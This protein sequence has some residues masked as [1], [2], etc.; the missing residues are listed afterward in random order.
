MVNVFQATVQRAEN[1]DIYILSIMFLFLETVKLYEV[2]NVEFVQ[3]FWFWNY[4]SLA[5]T[6]YMKQFRKLKWRMSVLWKTQS[7]I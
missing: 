2:E 7:K 6:K 3:K 1:W 4:N 5:Q